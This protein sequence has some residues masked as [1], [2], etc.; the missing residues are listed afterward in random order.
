MCCLF[1]INPFNKFIKL[2]ISIFNEIIVFLYML[3]VYYLVSIDNSELDEQYSVGKI[4][5][6]V[7]IV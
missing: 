2:S 4:L 6:F 3:I 7:G 5:F 1:F